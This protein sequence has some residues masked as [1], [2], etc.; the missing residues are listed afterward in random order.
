ME[1]LTLI[2]NNRNASKTIKR[3]I[4]FLIIFF[5][6]SFS[7]H[8]QPYYFKHYQ[9]ESGL[10]NNTV[11]CSLQDK[12]GFL[13][14]GTKDGLNRFDGYNFKVFR[15]DPK[16]PQTIGSNYIIKLCEDDSGTIWIGCERGLYKYD[17][18]TESFSLIKPT[19]KY[20][21]KDVLADSKGNVWFIGDQVLCR[22]DDHTKKVKT[23]DSRIISA[24]SICSALDGTLFVSTA[25]GL[26][27]KYNPLNDSLINY[28]VFEKSKQLTS[29]WIKK[30]YAINN[31][32][33]LIGTSAAGVKLLDVQTGTY[34]DFLTYNKDKTAIYTRDIIKNSNDEYWIATES[35][36]F[37]Y[38]FK[39]GKYT[40]LRKQKNDPYAISDNAVYTF[41]K[42]NEGGIW[43]G[44][45]FGGINY[46]PK[47]YNLFEKFYPE[48][49]GNSISGNA[50]REICEDRLGN[51]W[52]GTE[53]AGLNKLNRKTGLFT[54]FAPTGSKYG[55]SY[56]NIH[57][58]LSTGNELWIGTFANGLDVMDI[59][60]EK[61]IRHFSAGPDIH[62]FKSNFIVTFYQTRSGEILVG[63]AFGLYSYN[64]NQNNF[65]LISQVPSNAWVYAIH[66]DEKG[67]I[68][69]G[70]L[71]NG[72]CY[73]NLRT[74]E[75][76]NYFL[77]I[78]GNDS[79]SNNYVNGIFEDSNKNIWFATESGGLY[80]LNDDRK[81]FKNFTTENGLPSNLILRILEDSKK[82]LWISTSKGLV[83]F[84]LVTEKIKVYTKDN[85]LLSD[86]FNYNSSF[87][88][89]NGKMYFGSVKGLIAFNPNEFIESTFR[90][91]VY[92]TGFQVNNE[93][94]A[95]GKDKSPLRKSI[96]YTDKIALQHDQSSFSIAFA[97]LSFTTPERI[98]YSYQTKGLN[99]EW[100]Y[101]NSNRK[102]YF[103]Q[104]KPGKYIFKVKATNSSGIWNAQEAKL[105]IEI[106]PPLWATWRAY[107]L[108]L[109]II[110]LIVVYLIKKYHQ[111][112]EEK[113]ERK[114]VL[115]QARKEKEL[116]QAKIDFF[117]NVAHEIKT[118]LT[119]IKGP[120]ERVI[121]KVGHVSE[122]KE[123]LDFLDKNT[124][125]LITLSNQ[126]LDFRQTEIKGFSLNFTELN[127]S[128]LLKQ[129]FE[130]FRSLAEEKNVYFNLC[131]PVNSVVAHA[132]AEALI[133]VLSNLLSNAIKYAETFVDVSLSVCDESTNNPTFIIK[134]KNN[135]Y[136]IPYEMKEKIFEPF[137]RLKET[138]KQKGTGIGLALSRSLVK[139]HN[140]SLDLNKPENGLNVFFLQIP[141]K[142][143]FSYSGVM[144]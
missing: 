82:N 90:P 95:V 11:L 15:N 120:L 57:G 137:F 122:I 43:A 38:N 21:I 10:S 125:R 60:T 48:D 51:L 96:I 87:E 113:N 127:I 4:F 45:Y 54:H 66:E 71:R 110:I 114:V 109:F 63:T 128:D 92:I 99:N 44:T 105:T 3:K 59:R 22:Y 139:L 133:K 136:L 97:A 70:T 36:I 74:K 91:P 62:S 138:E 28:N 134:F 76:G 20:N 93:E 140:G 72:V 32:S 47:Q 56:S 27:V 6:K 41:C 117:T 13:W 94:L 80:K 67:T 24:T 39:N 106:L 98:E 115:L 79:L 141:L 144:T 68:W 69:V 129:T 142:R 55:I 50:V 14:F 73:Y 64:R 53:D 46:Y 2:L 100:T 108:Y 7:L 123:Y 31:D 102:V 58:L 111:Y 19:I 103:T 130:N 104:L 77:H 132:D 18:S 81:S 84:N 9:V 107:C 124:N 42:D 86:Q 16:N 40:N 85:G 131:L 118:P 112:S 116:F 88:D 135:G 37:I 75:S 30:I 89:I 143:E 34:T 12:K 25:N 52:I 33:L 121:K 1:F 23:Y 78:K 29:K 17:A 61:V 49:G 126:F 35:G 65:I 5:I 83:C 8:S 26:V 101:L 119:L